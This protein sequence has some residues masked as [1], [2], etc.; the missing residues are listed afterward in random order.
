MTQTSLPTI[1]PDCA[2]SMREVTLFGRGLQK[3]VSA[4]A[5]DAAVVHY[6]DAKATRSTWLSMFQVEGDVRSMLCRAC[7]RLFLYG[8]PKPDPDPSLAETINCLQCGAQI[9]A[10]HSKC[11]MCGWSYDDA[12]ATN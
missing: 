10:S 4:A 3:S 12:P 2:G 8:V 5:V 11:P 7:G 1:C 6:T 9:E